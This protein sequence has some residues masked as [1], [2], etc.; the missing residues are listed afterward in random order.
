M[1][2]VTHDPD[3]AEKLPPG[4][5]DLV[6]SGHTHGGQVTLFGRWAFY[7]PSEYG[8]KYRTGMVKNAATTSSSPTA[9]GPARSRRSGSSPGRR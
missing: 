9:S 5:V 4:A 6:L 8:Q 1:L 2:L 7:V 3:Y